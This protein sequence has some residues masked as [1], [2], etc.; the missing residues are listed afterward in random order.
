MNRT[1]RGRPRADDVGGARVPS[2]RNDGEGRLPAY[3]AIAGELSE[4]IAT[5][6]YVPGSRLPSGAQVCTEFG[7]SPMTARRALGSL[8]NQGLISCVQGRGSFVRSPDL[9]KS[10]FRLTSASGDWLDSSA[11]VRLLSVAM[12]RADAKTARMLGVAEGQRVVSLRRLVTSG[13]RPAMYHNE[14]VLHD[15]R[16][17]LLESQLQ[18][19]SLSAF[20]ESD[21][22]ERFPQGDLTVTAMNLD[23][24]TADAL[25]EPEGAAALCLE[26]LF[27]DAGGHPVSWGYLFLRSESFQLRAQMGSTR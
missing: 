25:G 24:E 18:L 19:M 4:R 7:V 17:P 12:S 27:L 22:G 9:S 3:L 6:V 13:A 26:H 21:R 20:L 8:K 11:E 5:G 23:R 15:P 2:A 1:G 14:F 10:T 16:R